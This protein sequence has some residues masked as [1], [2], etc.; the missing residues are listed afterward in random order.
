MFSREL[1]PVR[2]TGTEKNPNPNPI[3]SATQSTSN[4]IGAARHSKR[5]SRLR[6]DT[7]YNVLDVVDDLCELRHLI[8]DLGSESL[9]ND[10]TGADQIDDW[11]HDQFRRSIQLLKERHQRHIDLIEKATRWSDPGQLAGLLDSARRDYL[12]IKSA[13]RATYR[14]RGVLLC[15]NDW[16]SP[17]Y[18]STI[19][20]GENRLS[21]GIAEHRWDYKR[22][23]HLDA[24]EYEKQFLDQYVAH[25]GSTCAVG[26]LANCG[27]AAFTTMLS[28]I[29]H[30]L[31]LGE[32]TVL[33]QPMY[34][35]NLHLARAFF[36][37]ALQARPKSTDESI[38]VLREQQPS[39]VFCDAV[40]NCGDVVSF[41]IAAIL[42]WAAN[43]TTN[44]TA[45]VIDT[46]CVPA[47]LLPSG[48]LK[49]LPEHVY[50]VLVE[51]LAK[52]HQFGMDTVTGG[53]SILHAPEDLHANF[54]KARARF[55]GNIADASV[56]ALPKPNREA[57]IRRMKR[58]SQ[59]T[60]FLADRLQQYID[61][62]KSNKTGCV[63]ESLSWLHDGTHTAQWYRGS[64]LNLRLHR[65]FKSVRHYQEFEAKVVELS[66]ACG[67]P[68]ALSTS[69]GFDV[70]RLYVTAP[71]TPFEEPFLRVSLGTETTS[72]MTVFAEILEQASA[73]MAIAWNAKSA[74]T[75]ERE[76]RELKDTR[77]A[78][79]VVAPLGRST[80]VEK[81]GM[82]SSVF[83]GET[84]LMEYLSPQNYA[85]TPL[86]E[87]PSDLNPFRVD[88]VRIFAKVMSLVP[89]MNIK[90]IPAFSMLQKAADR[91]ELA[92][93][94][95]IIESSSS[96][97]VLSLSVIARLFGVDNTCAIVDHSIPP[98]LLRMLR[99]FGIEPYM[100]PAAGHELFGVLAPRS[101]R[102]SDMGAQPGW[103]NP[104]QYTNPDNPEGFAKWLAPD[105]WA[106]TQG[107]LAVLSCGLG[108]CGTMV[109]IS[110]A[111]RERNP[112]I[113]VV[114]NCPQS[115]HLIPG[116]RESSLLSDVTFDWQDVA[117]AR[118]ELTAEEG[119]A[120]SIKLL[121]RGIMGGP[122]SGMNYA[123][124]LKY[125]AREKAA[126]RLDSMK[127]Q[128]EVWLAFLCCD[129][130][131]PHVED[132]YN[133]LGESYFPPI[134]PVPEAD[135]TPSID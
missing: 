135:R 49:G 111:L 36:P 128:G 71:S 57:F 46:T 76:A 38:A 7:I 47:P 70:S 21:A 73:E 62:S 84:A 31:R 95:R 45:I 96:N 116:P 120:A 14:Q 32:S 24:L 126:G 98:G 72:E 59:N 40:T 4:S 61:S 75:G 16:Q 89:L 105:L 86:V 27:M 56:G 25:L 28:W 109:G 94:E 74:T 58:H 80:A 79:V 22:D 114:A 83:M 15:A 6:G 87:L 108:T 104:G 133:T 29:A 41:D 117:N 69:F 48:L 63:L 82:R 99:L 100:H 60:R 13:L 122:S 102:A 23:G 91:G 107:R 52:H 68:I 119:F 130:P 131:L 54:R 55:G 90:S 37:H 110:R 103:L 77:P 124:A 53:I 43:E 78:G 93:V 30:E 85:P 123:G 42:R 101:Q 67:H 132:Y 134:H 64:C 39:V 44:P 65:Q 88:G 8:E 129:S 51:S 97:T 92:K 11:S 81:P 112:N 33:F 12:A 34:F 5:L 118:M 20:I 17:V 115:G 2:T 26:Y 66:Q 50:V 125:L 121:R 9:S 10:S 127:N 113:Q 3:P 1:T 18:A 35:E 19:A 106:Q